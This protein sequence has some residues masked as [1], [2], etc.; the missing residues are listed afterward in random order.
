MR[1]KCLDKPFCS[2][3]TQI[4]CVIFTFITKLW[5]IRPGIFLPVKTIT[6]IIIEVHIKRKEIVHELS[7][8]IYGWQY[9]KKIPW[10]CHHSRFWSK[11]LEKYELLLK[12]QK[13]A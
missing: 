9:C 10:G 1:A 11:A 8:E 6:K 4:L 2:K 3:R 7:V 5:K 13:S 12:D